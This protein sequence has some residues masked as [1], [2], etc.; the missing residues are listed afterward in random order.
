MTPPIPRPFLPLPKFR[1]LEKQLKSNRQRCI[2]TRLW[3]WKPLTLVFPSTEV[4]DKSFVEFIQKWKEF[5]L[6]QE[7]ER[8]KSNYFVLA[9]IPHYGEIKLLFGVDFEFP[10]LSTDGSFTHGSGIV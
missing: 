10:F 5:I 7:D 6:V 4:Y 9:E 1:S 8:Q 3:R 2:K